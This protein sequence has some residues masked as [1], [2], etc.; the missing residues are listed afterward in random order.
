MLFRSVVVTGVV[1][2]VEPLKWLVPVAMEALTETSFQGV[3]TL[4][5]SRAVMLVKFPD[6]APVEKFAENVASPLNEALVKFPVVRLNA[7][8]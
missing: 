3:V 5:M 6:I 4:L 2:D 7:K 8:P 1:V